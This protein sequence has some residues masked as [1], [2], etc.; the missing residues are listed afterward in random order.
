MA[1][2]DTSVNELVI[3]KLTQAQYDALTEKSPTELYFVTDAQDGSLPDQ[4]DN[5]GKFL[6]TDGE[7]VSW[8][9]AVKNEAEDPATDI[10]ILTTKTEDSNILIGGGKKNGESV[11]NAVAIGSQYSGSHNVAGN[12][13]VA[14][15]KAAQAIANSS[16]ALGFGSKAS[17]SASVAIGNWAQVTAAGAIQLNAKPS[18]V[19]TNNETGTFKVCLGELLGGGGNYKLLDIDGTI[20]TNRYATTPTDAGTYVPK[21]TI[22]EDGTATREWGTESGSAGGSSFQVVELPEVTVDN[23]GKIVQYVGETTADYNNGYFYK[24][25]EDYITPVYKLTSITPFFVQ[26]VDDNVFFKFVEDTIRSQGFSGLPLNIGLHINIMFDPM[27][28]EDGKYPVVIVSDDAAIEFQVFFDKDYLLHSIGLSNNLE[29]FSEAVDMMVMVTEPSSTTLMWK[30][31]DV[32]P[33]LQVVE[34]PEAS[35]E[36]IGQIVQYIGKTSTDYT[37]GYFYK[38][39]G[40]FNLTV[41]SA[42]GGAWDIVE[43][44]VNNL[45]LFVDTFGNMLGTYIL[46]ASPSQSWVMERPSG[47]MYNATAPIDYGLAITINGDLQTGMETT[48]SSGVEIVLEYTSDGFVWKQVNTQPAS[49]GDALP[50]QT[51]NAGKFL[52]TDGTTTSWAKAL[53]NTAD[54]DTESLAIGGTVIPAE[55]SVGFIAIGANSSAKSYNS[56]FGDSIAIGRSAIANQESVALGGISNAS[57]A[58]S[59]VIGR[60]A[61]AFSEYSTL[62]GYNTYSYGSYSTALGANA[63]VS[64]D[65]NYAIQIGAGTNSDANTFKVAT[66]SGNF[67]IMD[68]DGNVPLDRLTY[69]TDQIGDISTALTAILGE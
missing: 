40:L 20:P 15:G 54:E 31:V 23:L 24:S 60:S 3:N 36:N 52:M 14:I 56:Y 13:A 58:G 65:A 48:A 34:I 68:A 55:G 41:E 47:A 30:Q 22:A 51:D 2:V 12:S 64:A 38:S 69:V 9:N 10:E 53:V 17:K 39:S 33:T 61:R 21:L 11:K 43:A 57:G 63:T 50:D 18:S 66:Q 7:N 25:V 8:G 37:N 44:E 26:I 32:Q 62:V 28:A 6:T 29:D 19:A 49:E 1:T 42:D 4:T 45:D 27:F 16:I 59:V 35:E 67:E 46:R 5:A